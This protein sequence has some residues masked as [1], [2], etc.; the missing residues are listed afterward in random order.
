MILQ[1]GAKTVASF[2]KAKKAVQKQAQK[3]VPNQVLL[4]RRVKKYK[5]YMCWIVRCA[6]HC[7]QIVVCSMNSVAAHHSAASEAPDVRTVQRCM[8]QQNT[9]RRCCLP[10]HVSSIARAGQDRRQEDGEGG[11]EGDAVLQHRAQDRA[12]ARGL[13]GRCA[14]SCLDRTTHAKCSIYS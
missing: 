6:C 4:L 9:Q 11:E 8:T 5:N 1:N 13:V 3:V 12:L 2:G 14:S 7:F 10:L